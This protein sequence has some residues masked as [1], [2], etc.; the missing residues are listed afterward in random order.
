MYGS[1]PS[2]SMGRLLQEGDFMEKETAIYVEDVSKTYQ[3]GEVPVPVLN[4]V[5]F[6]VQAGEL[7]AVTGDSG[8]GKTTLMNLLGALDTPDSGRIIIGRQVISNMSQHQ[9]TLYRRNSLG[10]IYQDFNLIQVLNVY[11]NI[12][13]PLQLGKKKIE[14]KKI[15]FMLEKL[16]L[17]DKKY[18]LPSQLS[19]G[20]QQRV[21]VIRALIHN[22]ALILADEPTG[23]LDSRNTAMVVRLMQALCRKMNRTT[24]MVTHNMQIARLCDRVIQIR[25]GRVAAS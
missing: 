24:I 8:S 1:T 25:D 11:E 9:R 21:A 23:N 22:P 14:E 10:F 6:T 12:V 5:S 18:A 4:H 16:R 7:L 13:L 15:D 17:Q 19:G 3:N 20:E 2:G